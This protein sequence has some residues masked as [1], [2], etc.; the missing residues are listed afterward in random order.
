MLR[1]T[2]RV[3]LSRSLAAQI[4]LASVALGTGTAA[5]QFTGPSTPAGRVHGVVWIDV[6]RDGVRDSGE[7]GIPG[8]TVYADV[9][10]N[11][12]RDRL[13]IAVQ[14]EQDDPATRLDDAGE[15]TLEGVPPGQVPIRI[16]QPSDGFPISPT[17]GAH[18]IYVPLQ[19]SVSGVDFGLAYHDSFLTVSPARID[20]DS[21]SGD[22][23]VETAEVSIAPLCVLPFELEAVSSD[24]WALFEAL[25]G[26]Q[27]N[28]CGGD[29]TVFD[30]EFTPTADLQCY[31]LLV[32]DEGFD[33]ILTSIPIRVPEPAT[34]ISLAIGGVGLL[35]ASIRRRRL[36]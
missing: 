26:P 17:D 6:D 14:T 7:P 22:A 18:A 31:Q 36:G 34:A 30:L 24:P 20:V 27:L 8:V 19:D 5:A 1:P 12:I 2:S 25:D 33:T 4:L 15:Y 28:G 29:T 21:P 9:N 16:E 23:V 13:D 3:R 32:R 35:G 10:R 11:C